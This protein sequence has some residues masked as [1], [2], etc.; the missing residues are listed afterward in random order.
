MIETQFAD[1]SAQFRGA[2]S[3]LLPWFEDATVTDVFINGCESL[4]V[5]TQGKTEALPS[6]FRSQSE[7][8]ELI[9]RIVTPLGKRVDAARPYLDGVLADGSRFHLIQPPLVMP[10][11][12]LSIRRF[13][14]AD[15]V[16]LESFGNHNAISVLRRWV[17]QRR[18]FV[19]GGATG[20]GKTTLLGRLLDEALPADRVVLIE[21]CPEI[22]T[23][24]AHVLRLVS[25]PPTPDGK[26]EVTLRDLVRNSLRMRPDRLVVG[27][28]RGPEVLDFLQAMS[29]GHSGC[30]GTVHAQSARDVLQRLE[31]LVALS[32][33]GI[34]RSATKQWISSAVGGVVFLARDEKGRGIRE[35]AEVRG[36]EGDHFRL[37]PI[38]LE[39]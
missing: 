27:E 37:L 9:E 19:V 33:A 10:G 4:Y 29:T 13:R 2:A 23:R 36:W 8:L 31:T 20:A 16:P 15:S 24:L 26:G 1:L 18:N 12:A 17:S 30:L 14:A 6:P 38:E 28:C 7:I 32:G 21:E 22:Q 3:A 11:P 25:R 34:E 5:D 39:T 35:L